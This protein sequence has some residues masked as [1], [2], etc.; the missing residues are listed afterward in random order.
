M[1]WPLPSTPTSGAVTVPE[2]RTLKGF[3]S[4]SF[5]L[6][7]RSPAYVPA[8]LASSRTVKVSDEPA[9]RLVASASVSVY[10]EATHTEPQVS[11][12]VPVLRTVKVRDSAV[13]AGVV[14]KSVWSVALGLASP[15]AMF[16]PL[17][18]TPTS[19]AVGRLLMLTFATKA[20]PPP[21]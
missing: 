14:P 7:L 5:V 4:P 21:L 12:A 11:V 17:P 16:W 10:P 1:F 9:A 18:S 13:P 15:S 2:M 6:K 8:V 19:G 20:S 3:S